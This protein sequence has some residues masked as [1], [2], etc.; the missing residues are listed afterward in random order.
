MQSNTFHTYFT[1]SKGQSKALMVLMLLIAIV[2][3]S[4][5]ALPFYIQPNKNNISNELN[6]WMAT[7]KFDTSNSFAYASKQDKI[8]ASKLTPFAFDPNTLDEKGFRKLGLREKLISTLINYRN[9]GGKFYNKESLK[10]IYGL[11]DDEYK[12]L[13]AFIQIKENHQ[14]N[15]LLQRI[16]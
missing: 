5:I 11:Q 15:I 16:T 8:I 10:R 9:K 7:V 6:D 14:L 2:S 1:F 12:Q 4:Y 13:A 3:I